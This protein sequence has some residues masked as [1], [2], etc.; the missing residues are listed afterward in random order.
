MPPLARSRRLF[1]ATSLVLV[2]TILASSAA[3]R[4]S[5][6]PT[7]DVQPNSALAPDGGSVDLQLIASC[8]DR[9]TVVNTVVRAS[10]AGATGEASFS[11]AC[12]GALRVVN[13]TVPAAVGAFVLGPVQLTASLVVAR[14]RTQSAQD[15]ETV[16]LQPRVDVMIAGAGRLDG[17]DVLIDV[18]TACPVGATGRPSALGVTQGLFTGVGT[19][20]VVCDSR[21]HTATVRVP[22]GFVAGAGRALTFA[23]V[24]YD[25]LTFTGVADLPLVIVG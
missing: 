15:A 22:G 16:E 21:S 5:S 9:F 3:A 11:L 8:P 25:G 10:Q 12:T 1:V 20:L 24:V 6:G 17:D 4:P 23:D 18:T 7:V 14:G 2:T 13:V 19:Y